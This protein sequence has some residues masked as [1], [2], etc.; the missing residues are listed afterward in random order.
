VRISVEAAG[1]VYA[2]GTSI[3]RRALSGVSLVIEAG[4]SVAIAGSTGSG[5]STL[6]QLIAGLLEPSEGKVLL[7]G[8]TASSRK[9]AGRR[10]RLSLGVAFQ[11]PEDQLFAETVELD[12]AF[13]PRNRGLS[14]LAAATVALR[15]IEEAG[16]DR[17]L[18]KRSPFSLSGGEMRRVA[19]A[20]VLA[21]EP[22]VLILDE[23][24][25]GLDPAGKRALENRLLAWRIKTGATLI[26]VSHDPAG[27]VALADRLIIMDS[28]S[29]VA[30]GPVASVFSSREPVESAGL[31][32]P[33]PVLILRA[34]ERSG[35]QVRTD[36]MTPEEAVEEILRASRLRAHAA[37]GGRHG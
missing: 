16:L 36:L 30:D 15:S 2:R 17:S 33:E 12:V 26:V 34:L 5:K 4:E 31:F 11:R 14:A 18:A 13:G 8:V 9:A 22:E 21:L 3:E 27:I 10:A 25:A 23:P 20:G 24:T 35:W 7:D 28:G 19:L 37:E 32:P 6:I 29:L 1:F